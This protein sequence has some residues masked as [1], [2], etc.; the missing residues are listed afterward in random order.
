MRLFILYLT[1]VGSLHTCQAQYIPSFKKEVIFSEFISEGANVADVD[2]DGDLDVLAGHY[3]FENPCWNTHEI[4]EPKTFDYTS[5]Y[6]L[7]FLNFVMDVDQDGWVDFICFRSPGEAVHWYQ[8]PQG[9]ERHWKE[10]LIDSMA[11]NE[12]PMMVDIDSDGRGEL[13]FGNMKH[14]EMRWYQP[15]KK[16]GNTQWQRV[17]VGESHKEGTQRY[18][19]GLGWGDIDGDSIKDIIVR[20]GWWKV[21]ADPGTVLWTFHSADLGL[22][23]SQMYAYDFDGDGDQDVLSASAHAYGIWWHEQ[24]NTGGKI[25]FESHLIDTSFS[26][27]HGVAFTD[28][29]G[30]EL[31]DFVTGK[32]YFAHLGKDP[33]GNEPAV[34]YWFEM[35]RDED[36]IPTWTRH[37]IDDDSGIGIHVVVEDINGDGKKDIL[38]GNKK[39]III[40]WGE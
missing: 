31:P 6:S 16:P 2:N 26:Q 19:H 37:D 29:N 40:F 9:A 8:N 22:P 39:G 21:P 11:C 3:W 30:D 25:S 10:H 38:N 4:R 14:S 33:G 36:N 23:C 24:K 13:V 5:G 34:I 15:P 27:T 32:R 35:R 28:L 1:V 17:I 7:S 18:S 20:E 12:S